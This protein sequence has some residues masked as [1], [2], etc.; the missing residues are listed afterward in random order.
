MST[1]ANHKSL[2][3]I[4]ISLILIAVAA[5]LIDKA[6]HRSTQQEPLAGST[7]DYATPVTSTIAS[8][9]Q[10]PHINDEQHT[11]LTESRANLPFTEKFVYEALKAVRLDENGNVIYDHDALL[12]L[13][14]ALLRMQNKLDSESLAALQGIIKQ[15]LPNKAGEQT[16]KI[17]ADYYY[18]LEAKDEF[19]RTTEA[20]FSN[21]GP[22]TIASLEN[23]ETLYAELQALRDVH[24]GSEVSSSLF[25]VSDATAQYM[26]DSMKLELNQDLSP[27]EKEQQ[28][29]D[30]EEKH[31]ERSIN[32]DNWPI[33]YRNF[34]IEKQNILQASLDQDEKNQQLNQLLQSHFNTDEIKR[35]AH[36]GLEKL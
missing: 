36:L 3:L 10:W 27:V 2:A 29:I 30:I 25:R 32:V 28:L 15:G 11:T 6:Q 14:E 1:I 19:S 24:L 21:T 34:Q 33:R 17:V 16:A 18:Y 13:D 31:I 12:S 26:F 5:L 9:W 7:A 35:I 23:D 4:V 20:L 8:N 22:A